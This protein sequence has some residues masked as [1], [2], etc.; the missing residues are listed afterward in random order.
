MVAAARAGDVEV[1]R[2]R[3][4]E[5]LLPKDEAGRQEILA[6]GKTALGAQKEDGTW[7]DVDYADQA[8]SVWKLQQHMERALVMA[9]ACELARRGNRRDDEMARGVL[10]AVDWWIAHDPKNP[11]WWWNEI[12][13]P[14]FMGEVMVIEQGDASAEEVAKIIEIMKRSKWTGWTGQNLVWGCLN[15]V[16]RGCIENSESII[17]DGYARMYQEVVVRSQDWDGIQAD[18]SFHQHGKQFYSGGY[19]LDFAQDV[20]RFA[21]FAWGTKWQIPGQNLAVLNGFMLDG[22]QW[23]MHYSR[24][25]FSGL[26]REITRKGKT[27]VSHSWTTGPIAPAGAAYTL[28]NS[29]EMMS[30]LPVPRQAEWEL[31]AKRLAEDRSAEALV[32]NRM[33]WCSDYMAHHRP[34]WFASI[35]MFSTRLLNTEMV[36]GEGKKSHHLADGTMLLYRRGTEY[37][38]IFPVWDWCKIPGTTAEQVEDLQKWEPGGYHVMGK[39]DFAGGVSDGVIGVAAMDLVRGKLSAKKMYVCV[40]DGVICMGAGINCDSVDEVVTEVNQCHLVGEVKKAEDLSWISH[41]GVTYVFPGKQSLAFSTG[42]RRGK[43]SD[44]GTGPQWEMVMPVFNLGIDH[45]RHVKDGTYVY[46]VGVGESKTMPAEVVSNSAEVQ[47]VKTAKGSLAAVF[48]KA[49]KAGNVEVDRP[50]VVLVR[51]G[52]VNVSDPT[53]KVER[54]NVKVDGVAYPVELPK[55]ERAGETVSEKLKSAG[56]EE[57]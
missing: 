45:G 46:F 38:D 14:Q 52:K 16:T 17:G 12:G 7:R 3:L 48:W 39:S 25:D 8:R 57:L 50:C 29:V 20:T 26:G 15:Q 56:L 24:F 33:Y 53:E 34:G 44:L 32:G 40:E 31:F 13:T 18:Y 51:E 54:V 1:V 21:V 11:N 30:K 9:K 36:N 28:L 37:T 5:S 42:L 6:A 41:D 35:K 22:E 10:R 2:G 43:W 23:M 55:G 19:G 49:G 4:V 27:A 47:M